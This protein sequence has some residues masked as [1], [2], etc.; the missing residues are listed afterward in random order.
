MFGLYAMP[1][2]LMSSSHIE[3]VQRVPLTPTAITLLISSLTQICILFGKLNVT[4]DLRID[5]RENTETINKCWLSLKCLFITSHHMIWVFPYSQIQ[6]SEF[7]QKTS[8]SISSS[9]LTE[10]AQLLLPKDGNRLSP[11]ALHLRQVLCEQ[12]EIFFYLYLF[13][14]TI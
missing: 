12:C 3:S 11:P 6:L 13:L 8:S 2:I 9:S 7:S 5:S 14:D 1:I 10:P 4:S